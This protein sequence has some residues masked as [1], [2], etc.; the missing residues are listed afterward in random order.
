MRRE[1]VEQL[2]EINNCQSKV[3]SVAQKRK[4]SHYYPKSC[5]ISA[6]PQRKINVITP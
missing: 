1:L 2:K 5:S 6:V 4:V 3:Y